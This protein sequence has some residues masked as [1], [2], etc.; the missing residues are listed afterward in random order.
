[1]R[2]LILDSDG[3]ALDFAVRA[4]RAG[5]KVKHYI[6]DTPKSGHIGK[7]WVDVIRDWQPWRRWADMVFLPDNCKYLR[8]A[9]AM[10]AD[11]IPIFGA[12]QASA[13]WEIDR[14]AGM[15]VL[16]RA[17][18]NIPESRIF[19]NYDEAIAYVKKE[20]RRF[21]SKPSGDGEA[22]KALSYCAK[23][24]ADMVYMLER[25]K[26]KYGSGNFLLQEFIPGIEMAVGGWFGPHGFNSAVCENFEF[27]KLM[28][29]DH[30]VATGEMGTVLHYTTKSKLADK[31]LYPIQEQLAKT[32]HVGYVDV[33]CIVDE[34]GEPWPLE[35]TMR[36]G[37]PTFNIQQTLHS[38]DC[39]EWM[40]DL[41]EGRD[42]KHTINNT[43][44]IGVCV[45]IPDF[46]YSHITRKDVIGVPVYGITPSMWE[47]IHP[48]EMMMGTAPCATSGTIMNLPTPVTAGDYVMVVTATGLTVVNAREKVYRRLE[49]LEIPN[50]PMWRTDIGMRL[51]NQL[52]RLHA[53]GLAKN[54]Q[55][56]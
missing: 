36:P 43:V 37:W 27:K 5:H 25:W 41:C 14:L 55:Y 4:Q 50:S 15:Q 19:K 44:A 28:V 40:L 10:K 2:I 22:D 49:R 35:F 42:A 38:G 33:N 54:L 16:R 52:P 56:N 12:T 32:G 47:N 9:D 53:M 20:D 6:R 7:G 30:G 23:S 26:K 48:C 18:V 3:I 24:P 11:G 45:A 17:K 13:P 8:D 21:V 29:G 1:M 31:V 51:S 46:P 34:R 39:A